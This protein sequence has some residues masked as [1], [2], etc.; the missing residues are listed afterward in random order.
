MTHTATNRVDTSAK[1]FRIVERL[2]ELETA[3]VSELSEDMGISKSIVHNHL[4]TLRELGYVR[5][6]GDAY[7]LSLRFLELGATVRARSAPSGTVVR[8]LDGVA[9][10]LETTVYIVER[11]GTSG[12]VTRV[13]TIAPAGDPAFAL[14]D[15]L[16]SPTSPL[17]LALLA[18]LPSDERTS[19]LE[20]TAGDADGVA[21][22]LAAADD[23]VF[24]GTMDAAGADATVAAGYASD[25]EFGA[26]GVDVPS[27]ESE[28]TVRSAATS[29]AGAFSTSGGDVRRSFA[30]TKHGWFSE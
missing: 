3:G 2:A 15:R 20:A 16:E 5:K 13:H 30:T 9:E 8:R 24:V 19:M 7:R 10:R 17:G 11:D 18:S 22:R 29:L 14:G 27:G 26:V 1:T 6:K 28:R 21:E 4:S 25:G 23:G 12:V